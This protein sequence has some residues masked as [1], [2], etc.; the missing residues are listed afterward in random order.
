MASPSTRWRPGFVPVERHA[1]GTED[2]RSSYVASVPAG[3]FG[4][5]EEI[6]HAVSLSAAEEAAFAT[7]QRLVLDGGRALS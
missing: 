6:A 1:R 4:T 7:G 5:R 2:V 3:R